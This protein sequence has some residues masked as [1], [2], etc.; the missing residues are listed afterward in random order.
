MAYTHHLKL[1]FLSPLPTSPLYALYGYLLSAKFS[2]ATRILLTKSTLSSI[3]DGRPHAPVSFPFLLMRL[4]L[5][6]HHL[7][8]IFYLPDLMLP[9]CFPPRPFS[10]FL[11][12]PVRSSQLWLHLSPPLM[13]IE[14]SLHSEKAWNARTIPDSQL[15]SALDSLSS[16]FTPV[17]HSSPSLPVLPF[18]A[19]GLPQQNFSLIRM[20]PAMALFLCTL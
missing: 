1:Q 4:P 9:T 20:S 7:S 10:P 15:T 3:P 2:Y 5:G 19:S 13:P 8:N 11:H 12:E 17:P 14:H 18:E 16:A 6:C